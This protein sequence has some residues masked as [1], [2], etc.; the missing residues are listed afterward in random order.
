MSNI[1]LNM[2]SA[3]HGGGFKTYNDNLLNELIRREKRAI[4]TFIFVNKSGF[5]F[6]EKKKT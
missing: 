5:I 4:I 6:K 3:L 2:V 1:A